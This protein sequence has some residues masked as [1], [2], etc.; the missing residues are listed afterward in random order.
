MQRSCLEQLSGPKVQQPSWHLSF[1]HTH[2]SEGLQVSWESKVSQASK[3]LSFHMHLSIFAQASAVPK[4][5][6]AG[7]HEPFHMQR[8]EG[9]CFEEPCVSQPGL[10]RLPTSSQLHSSKWNFPHWS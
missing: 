9:H 4:L 7:K 6:Q 2:L 3:H 10:D 8:S 5:W 1:F